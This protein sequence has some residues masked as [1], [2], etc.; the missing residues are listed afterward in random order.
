VLAGLPRFAANDHV[1]PGD[2][3]GAP[4]IGIEKAWQRIRKAAGLEDVRLHDL[5]HA[6]ASTAVAHGD[7]LFIVGKLLGHARP[8]TTNRYAHLAPDPARAAANRT[9]E[10]LAALLTG[11]SPAEVVALAKRST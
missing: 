11:A 1:I 2:R 10:R 9:G 8:E 3:P 6:F 5:R 4:F 7:S